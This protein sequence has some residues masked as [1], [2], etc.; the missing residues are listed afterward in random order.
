MNEIPDEARQLLEKARDLNNI[1]RDDEAI[2]LYQ[3]T[4]QLA[5]HWAT[6]YYNL[7]LIYK[8]RCDWQNSFIYNKK[9]SELDTQHQA[10]HWNL[11]IAATALKDWRTARKAWNVFGLNLDIN[12]NETVLDLGQTPVRLDPEGEAEV[13]WCS[14]ID[15][16]RTRINNVPLPESGRRY[17]DLLLNDGA[18]VGERISNGITYPVFNELQLL[19]KS[20]YKTFSAIVYTNDQS[21]IDKLEKL[22]LDEEIGFEDWSTI[23]LLCK[24]CSENA[25]HEQ[26]DH[27]RKITNE[28][29]THIGF[30]AADKETLQQIL[31][32]WAIITLAA[33]SEPMLEL[34]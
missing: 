17:G 9:A 19:E 20:V 12:D 24:K 4:I 8:Y 5:P 21:D 1:E 11:G 23:R 22:C 3:K 30:G 14:R 29:E 10:S 26:H 6:P 16:A 25:P 28:A 34:E 33:Y 7:G 18:P 15:P 13:V 27:D 2:S 32:N 31:C